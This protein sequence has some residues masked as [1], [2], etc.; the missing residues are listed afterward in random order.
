MAGSY[1]VGLGYDVHPFAIADTHRALVLGGVTIEGSPA[2]AGHS[3][4]DAVA[5]AVADALLGPSGLG[6]LGSLFPSSDDTYRDADS[7]A[8][9]ADVAARVRRVGWRVE[10]V[11]VVIAAEAPKLA[12]FVDAMARNVS[13]ALADLA[14]ADGQPV[15][16]SVKPKR[17]EGLG[18]VGRAEGVAAWAVAQL[19]R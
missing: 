12:P 1:R 6:D 10:N 13:H 5:H 17:G 2:L 4:A 15:F 11:D 8:L 9:L 18:F 3:D 19:V 16:V 14:P 7:M